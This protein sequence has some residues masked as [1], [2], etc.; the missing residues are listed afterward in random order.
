MPRRP[1]KRRRRPRPARPSPLADAIGES[2]GSGDLLV[3]VVGSGAAAPFLDALPPAAAP[4]AFSTA[5]SRGGAATLTFTQAR[6]GLTSR[7]LARDRPVVS[8]ATLCL[9]PVP[10]ALPLPP[11]ERG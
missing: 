7:E 4:L 5:L 10:S 11:G 6:R 3:P 2:A 8:R 1:R 9:Y